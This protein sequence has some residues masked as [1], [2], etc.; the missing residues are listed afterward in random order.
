[1]K[2]NDDIEIGADLT[3]QERELLARG[4][5]EWGGPARCTEELALAMGFA[6]VADIEAPC[7]C[8]CIIHRWCW[9]Q[10]GGSPHP[11]LSARKGSP[12]FRR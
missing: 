4:V 1:M 6:S 3:D 7:N 8:A 10:A 5:I 11:T 9:L 12:S 2:E